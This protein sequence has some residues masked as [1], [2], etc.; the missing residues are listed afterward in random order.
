M[1]AAGLLLPS[2][3][4]MSIRLLRMVGMGLGLLS[5]RGLS[6]LLLRRSQALSVIRFL[7]RLLKSSGRLQHN[8]DVCDR[9]FEDW[10]VY[11]SILLE[12]SG[13]LLHCQGVEQ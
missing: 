8:L 1:S 4:R 9:L 11:Q 6:S 12:Y 13:A 3:E 5:M 2:E 10:A 7:S